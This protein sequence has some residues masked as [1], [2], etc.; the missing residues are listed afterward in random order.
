[1]VK[2]VAKRSVGNQ[3]NATPLKATQHHPFFARARARTLEDLDDPLKA[4]EV[5]KGS[6]PKLV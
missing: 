4:A 5:K 1:V 6:N 2:R 3:E